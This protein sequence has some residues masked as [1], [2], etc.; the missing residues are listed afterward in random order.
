MWSSRASFGKVFLFV[1][2]NKVIHKNKGRNVKEV[3]GKGW[4]TDLALFVNVIA[5]LHNL[6]KELLGKDKLIT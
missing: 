5:Q 3:N 6:T 4:M 2:L 1:E